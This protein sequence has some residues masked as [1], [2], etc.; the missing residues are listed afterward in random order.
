MNCSFITETHDYKA[1]ISITITISSSFSVLCLCLE[2]VLF[3]WVLLF[4]VSDRLASPPYNELLYCNFVNDE[5]EGDNHA[6]F[7][8]PLQLV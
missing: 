3:L 7:T 2:C 4:I 6:W 1:L 8:A 5:E